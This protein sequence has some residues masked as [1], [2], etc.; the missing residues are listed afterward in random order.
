MR[1]DR[2]K[3]AVFGRIDLYN[4]GK[5][6]YGCELS[7]LQALREYVCDVPG[8]AHDLVSQCR[9]FVKCVDSKAQEAK[10]QWPRFLRG[11]GNNGLV[12]RTFGRMLVTSHLTVIDELMLMP[13]ELRE[14]LADLIGFLNEALY[15]AL[16]LLEVFVCYAR[17]DLE[18][19]DEFVDCIADSLIT[20]HYTLWTDDTIRTGQFWG[21]EI[22]SRLHGVDLAIFLVSSAFLK[23]KYIQNEELPVF[24]AR[25]RSEGMQ[26][27][28]IILD[29]CN[30][31]AQA[32]LASTQFF[33]RDPL[34]R[35]MQ[36]VYPEPADR[37]NA[38]KEYVLPDV[39][40][41]VGK[42]SDVKKVEELL[43]SSALATRRIVSFHSTARTGF[44]QSPVDPESEK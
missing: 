15:P 3:R 20:Q 41:V 7:I 21:D 26:I 36:K 30:W 28:P 22:H 31:E 32:W 25:R 9:L 42:L 34:E 12:G 23:S 16:S 35:G 24:I 11:R 17:G 27:L 1:V 13:A 43:R 6:C 18:A 38:Y 33:P 5:S 44:A 4:I 14:E 2:T 8:V 40:D 19:K 10:W 37:R 39:L 29:D